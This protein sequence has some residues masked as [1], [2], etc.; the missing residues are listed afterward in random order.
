[1]DRDGIVSSSCL[2]GPTWT[3]CVTLGKSSSFPAPLE[4]SSCAGWPPLAEPRDPEATRFST[5]A[6]RLHLWGPALSSGLWEFGL[7]G[8][9]C[10]CW[11]ETPWSLWSGS[12]YASPRAMRFLYLPSS[13]LPR[14]SSLP[15]PSLSPPIH[16]VNESQ[17]DAV[18]WG[19]ISR[20]QTRGPESPWQVWLC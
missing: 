6:E 18:C 14:P 16:P 2:P 17:G 10:D 3:R 5:A 9:R 19:C 11:G 20:W 7:L 15:A 12:P 13:S 4:T 1:M 8:G